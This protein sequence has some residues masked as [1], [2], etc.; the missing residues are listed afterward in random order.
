MPES[1]TPGTSDHD[2]EIA[3]RLRLVVART[4]R[5]LRS[6][7]V[8][9]LTQSQI[10]A[11]VMTEGHGPLRIGDLAVREGVSAPTMTRVVAAL[12]MAGHLERTPDPADARSSFVSVSVPG[13]QLLDRLR[14]DRTAYL[15]VRVAA[16]TS[17]DRDLLEAAL[18]VLE[19]L[20]SEESERA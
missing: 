10:S 19:H 2:V 17:A 4:A 14:R 3:T 15:A 20:G 13:Q 12:E 7:N 9:G 11:L 16:L 6:K 1:T 8:T 18:P 5:R